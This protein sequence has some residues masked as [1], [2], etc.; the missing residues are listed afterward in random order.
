MMRKIIGWVLA[1]VLIGGAAMAEDVAVE[2]SVL[3]ASQ[4]TLHLFPFL[5]DDD[6]RTLRLVAT[7]RDALSVF[8]PSKDATHFAALALSPADGFLL[9]GAPAPTAVAQSDFPDAQAA[10]TATLAACDAKRD[11]ATAPCVV[12]LEVG[13]AP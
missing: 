8:V 1:S 6:L 10:A 4:V 5:K 7:N 2:V 12:V 9:D 13:P 11:P 3:D